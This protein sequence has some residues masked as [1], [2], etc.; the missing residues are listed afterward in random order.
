MISE[1]GLFKD[2]AY[3]FLAAVLGGALAR[4]ARQPLILGYVLGGLL[5]SPLTPGPSVADI[6]TF[7]RFAEIGV[8]LLMF[9][10]GIEFSLKDLAGVKWIAILGG[11]L[12][13][14]MTIGLAMVVG[15]Q[16]GWSPTRSAV[17]GMVVSVASTMVLARLLLDRG[18]IHSRH[19]RILIGISLVE[20]LVVVVLIVL[21]PA[22]GALQGDRIFAIAK[23]LVT[24]AVILIPFFYLTRRI[25][26]P[27]LARVARTRSDELF[28][29]VALA[30]G[31]GAAALTQAAGLSLAL[32]AFLA[33]LLINESDYAHEMLSRL[34]SLRDAFVALFFVTVGVLIDPRVIA[35]NVTLLAVLVGIVVIGNWAIWTI[36]ALMFRQPLSTALLVG[37]G[38][39]Q[40]GEFSFVLVQ[41]ARQAGHVGLDVYNAT[42]AASLVTILLNA[43]LVRVVP[44]WIGPGRFDRPTLTLGLR[45]AQ[46]LEGHVVLC[47]FGR[48]GSAIGEALETFGV[49][50]VAIET[51][52]DIVKSLRA[53][54]VPAVFGDS[55]Q[56]VILAA[57]QTDRAALVIVAIPE[58]DRARLAVSRVRAL[59][60]D[61]PILARVLDVEWRARL[62]EA[63]AA[64]VIQPEQEAASTLIRHAL[65]RL[66]L[67]RDRV[68]AY[69]SRFRTAMEHAEAAAA[70]AGTG[71]P[72]IREVHLKGGSPVGRPLG[73]T[74]MRERFGVTLVGVTRQSGE[75]VLQPSA[76]TIL[77]VGDRLRLFGLPR[78]IEAM[79]AATDL[80][81]E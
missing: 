33:G 31:L 48:V 70:D 71:L 62:M 5:I 34:L 51:D 12:G 10:L 79:L 67:P 4:Y 27:V 15:A 44:G 30:I 37:V 17:V 40:I 24:A 81:I 26:P 1:P 8:I 69:L 55:A 49:P 54:N 50:Y 42:L 73:E 36:V 18:E 65:E 77:R 21:I 47:G 7:E 68:L 13:I 61:A 25:L 46:A 52:P 63:G 14:L 29:L 75:V 39:T 60:P 66:A 9:S 41:V 38:L 3:V 57:A 16:A 59:N 45:S 6:H 23:A 64:E 72:L 80:L 11:P 78:Q 35:T 76:E 2:L 20:D 74:R 43:V 58:S 53:R 28:L 22:L 56:R 19:G 32:G